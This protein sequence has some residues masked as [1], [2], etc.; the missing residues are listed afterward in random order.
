MNTEITIIGAGV[1]GLAI[2]AKL[3][4]SNKK[5]YLLERHGDFGQETSSRNSEVIHAGIYYIKNSL[6][7]ELCVKGNRMLYERCSDVGIPAINCGKLI[8]ATCVEELEYLEKLLMKAQDNGVEK[9]SMISASQTHAMEPDVT[10]VGSLFAETTGIIDS[11]TLMKHL[12]DR[13]KENGVSTAFGVN[14]NSIIKEADYK[15]RI[16]VTDS[17]GTEFSYLSRFVINCAGLES[18]RLALSVGMDEFSEKSVIN[19][20]KG[21]YFS[22]GNGKNKFIKRLIYPVPDKNNISLGIH[23]TPDI[24][25]RLKLGPSAS[26]MKE[27][28]YDYNVD[29]DR[30]EDFYKSTSK[31]LPFLEIQDLKPELSGIRPKLQ[32][33]GGL[34]RDFIIRNEKDNGFSGFINL[35]GIDSPGLTS[36]LAIAEYVE[37]IFE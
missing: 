25:G 1:V 16:C 30:L 27:R 8:V 28:N 18:D 6:K 31:Y 3:S 33:P 21:D 35:V 20:C 22:V 5:S 15:Y 12:F 24:T 4:E 10:S 7:A 17:D 34:E 32:K 13:G 9:I 23:V 2:A 19:F 37:S 26:F 11:H 36:S 14:V 29:L